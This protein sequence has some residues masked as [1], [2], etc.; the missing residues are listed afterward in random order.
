MEIRY[1]RYLA[2]IAEYGTVT[3]AARSLGI[4]QSTLSE[5]ILRLEAA[6]GAKLLLRNARGVEL[7]AAGA[8]VL[9]DAVLVL[10]HL[11]ALPQQLRD[12]TEG[13]SGRFVLGC[14]HSLGAWF[15]PQVFSR[16]IV[17]LPDIDL[18]VFSARS[19]E[20]QQAVLERECDLGLV[21]NALPQ[22]DLVLTTVCSDAVT[23]VASAACLGQHHSD[24]RAFLMERP[25]FFLE[26]PPFT[27]LLERLTVQ[28]LRPGRCVPLGDLEMVK[29]LAVA[30]VGSAVLPLRVA[31]YG[32]TDLLPLDPALPRM[33]D[34]VHLIVRYDTPRVR[35]LLA[36]RT[37]LAEVGAA[38]QDMA[39]W[40]AARWPKQVRSI[41]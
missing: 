27:T 4:A 39:A 38:L 24:S 22:P 31:S 8:L 1:L 5:G 23:V 25:L 26:Q 16:L 3:R 30:G 29:A 41:G 18:Q 11:D 36:L 12:L 10:R 14:Y 7:T 34:L 9:S 20:V 2:A 13:L 32:Q 19:S 40:R 6:L 35:A 17:E 21:I 37:L 33:D 28:G 15:L